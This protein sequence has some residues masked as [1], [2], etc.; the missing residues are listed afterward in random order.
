M[1]ETTAAWIL[2]S[3]CAL[4]YLWFMSLDAVLATPMVPKSDDDESPTRPDLR[5]TLC[6][7]CSGSGR[8]IADGTIVLC[9]FCAGEGRV[10]IEKFRQWKVRNA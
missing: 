6:P 9:D 1:S 7:K 2:L 10:D 4:I 8:L 5:T 3:A